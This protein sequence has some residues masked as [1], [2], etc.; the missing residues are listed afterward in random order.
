MKI[1]YWNKNQEP[2]VRVAN[3]HWEVIAID[4]RYDFWEYL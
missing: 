4:N 1:K 2:R 3:N